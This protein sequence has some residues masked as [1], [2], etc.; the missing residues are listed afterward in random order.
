MPHAVKIV[1]VVK[2]DKKRN[3]M[4]TKKIKKSVEV[5]G[6]QNLE[7]KKVVS[8]KSGDDISG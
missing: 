6:E 2:R 5:F 4:R 1:K 7:K 8:L 3:E